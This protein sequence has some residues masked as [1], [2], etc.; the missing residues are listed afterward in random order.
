MLG[1]NKTQDGS[2]PWRNEY[3]ESINAR[4]HHEYLNTN[5]LYSLRHTQV[6]IG[7]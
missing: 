7:D 6:A 5:S 1:R 2:K 3:I 4:L